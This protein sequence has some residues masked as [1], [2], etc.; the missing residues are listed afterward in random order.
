MCDP[1]PV[2][3]ET[4]YNGDIKLNIFYALNCMRDSY[5]RGE[6]PIL[7][8]LLWTRIPTGEHVGD[9][10]HEYNVK[11]CGRQYALKCGSVWRSLSH[12]TII[13][14]D[15]GISQGM[16]LAIREAKSNIEFRQLPNWKKI[17]DSYM[18]NNHINISV[19]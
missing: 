9:E 11:N 14:T 2:M 17:Y 3:V 10:N 5:T 7:T 15:L 6:S 12:K 18:I 13:Y 16:E 1:V 8:H 19:K 4:P